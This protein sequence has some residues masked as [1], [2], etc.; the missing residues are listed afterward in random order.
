MKN[1]SKKRKVRSLIF[2]DNDDSTWYAVA[3]EFNLVESGDTP[4]EA[5]GMLTRAMQGYLAAVRKEKFP[6]KFLNKKASTEYEKLWKQSQA[7]KPSK[8]IEN[9]I[10]SSS[11]ISLPSLAMA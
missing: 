9:T 4:G 8:K 5:M 7:A 1:S 2:W 3:L 6:A 11:V 10:F